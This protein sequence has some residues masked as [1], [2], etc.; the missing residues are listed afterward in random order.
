MGT[1]LSF[2]LWLALALPRVYNPTPN[3]DFCNIMGDKSAFERTR[4]PLGSH[5]HSGTSDLWH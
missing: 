5:S 1:S 4:A 2:F 3:V